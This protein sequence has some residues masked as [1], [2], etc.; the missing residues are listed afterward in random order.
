VGLSLVSSTVDDSDDD[1]V[2]DDVYLLEFPNRGGLKVWARGIDT[3]TML[4]LLKMKATARE[5]YAEYA[6]LWL[7]R[8]LER[9]NIKR[10]NGSGEVYA[11]PCTHDGLLSLEF[12]LSTAIV[13]AWMDIQ[14][15]PAAASPLDGS[16]PD[17]APSPEVPMTMELL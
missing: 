3:G 6:L 9:W 11:V 5:E 2:L 14:A 15:G 13:A 16:S 7:A 12:G 1:Y 4:Q 8:K 10:R 17:G